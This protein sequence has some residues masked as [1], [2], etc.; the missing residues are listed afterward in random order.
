MAHG[1][2]LLFVDADVEA[3]AGAINALAGA[4][5]STGGLVSV[6][7]FHRVE[8]FYEQASA[9]PNLVAVMDEAA[10]LAAMRSFAP[11]PSKRQRDEA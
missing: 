5:A 11:V 2:V 10:A 1:D 3:T 8:R 9:I 4:A 7:P 6:M